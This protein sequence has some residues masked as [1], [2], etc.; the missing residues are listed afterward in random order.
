MSK[1]LSLLFLIL[2]VAHLV[3]P[4]GVPGLR[5]RADFWKIALAGLAIFSLVI[6]IRP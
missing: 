2:M 6:L 3:R 4:F 1:I 5:R